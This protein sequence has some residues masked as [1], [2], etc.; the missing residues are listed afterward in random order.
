M[1]DQGVP[2]KIIQERTGTAHWKPL[3]RMSVRMNINTK[4]SLLFFHRLA[5]LAVHLTTSTL[6][7]KKRTLA[8]YVSRINLQTLRSKTCMVV[9][10]T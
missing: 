1:Y 8:Q 5:H 7:E 2:E 4:L 3:G 6:R 9:L 10:S